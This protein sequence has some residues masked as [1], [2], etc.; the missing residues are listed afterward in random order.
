MISL[1]MTCSAGAFV[2]IVAMLLKAGSD[3]VSDELRG[4]LEVIPDAILRMAAMHLPC[5]QR[6]E[7][8]REIWQ[9]DLLFITRKA[10][11][12][13]ITKF[14]T[15]TRYSLCLGCPLRAPCLQGAIERREPWGVW[16]GQ[17]FRRGEPV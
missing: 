14:L 3:L 16:G 1:I 15:S 12:R 2:F 6:L 17:V 11:R 8:Y 4:W 5:D 7:I 10:G 9:P 13:P